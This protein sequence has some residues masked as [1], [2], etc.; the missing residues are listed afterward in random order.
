MVVNRQR[1]PARPR[2]RL[3]VGRRRREARRSDHD[4]ARCGTGRP[5]FSCANGSLFAGHAT[6]W[7]GGAWHVNLRS[8]SASP[9]RCLCSEWQW[10]AARRTIRAAT[11]TPVRTPPVEAVSASR[12]ARAGSLE[13]GPS[14]GRVKRESLWAGEARAPRKQTRPHVRPYPRS[15]LLRVRRR[16]RQP[17]H[18]LARGSAASTRVAPMMS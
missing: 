8:R 2:G 6:C 14:L 1:R 10:A 4:A 18:A 15:W 13:T 5:P 12:P 7:N 9:P 16:M 11:Q 17:C 3:T